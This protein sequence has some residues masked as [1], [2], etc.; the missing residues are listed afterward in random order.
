MHILHLPRL[1]QTMQSGVINH[2]YVTEGSSFEVGDVLYEL[3]TEKMNTDVEAKLPG[4]LA[5][6]VN[7]VGVEI[8]IGATLAVVADPGET[9][10]EDDIADALAGEQAGRPVG[11]GEPRHS[12]TEP[13]GADPSTRAVRGPAGTYDP[14]PV[15]AADP[16]PARVRAMPRARA[17][18]AER[19]L[20]LAAISGTGPG[21]SI[22]VADV[23]N[24]AVPP[25]AAGATEP[26]SIVAVR[27]RR[28]VR[29]IARAM[30]ENVTRS[31]REVPQFVQQTR[32]DA[33]ALQRRR[34]DAA[35]RGAPV[36]LTA[37]LIAAIAHAVKAV[38]EANA[39]FQGEEIVLYSDVNVSV[40]IAT[41][42][43]LI[44]PVLHG[45]QKLDPA[46]VASGVRDLAD[47]AST[48]RLGPGDF[49]SGTIT[50]S[51]LGM[52][53]VETGFPLVTVPQ[54]VIVFAGAVT[55]RP[56][57]SNGQVLV[58]PELGLAIGFDHRV[59]DGATAARFTSALRGAL[60]SD[61]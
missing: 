33:S 18:A 44:V 45:A 54:A 50:V 27:E 38:P 32:A 56:V 17:L 15:A 36:S 20:D 39:S 28:P 24:A 41:D 37:L 35:D 23:E 5:R 31:W 57:V 22:T 58:R 9:L 60:E 47:K 53:G 51:N 25:S 2:W 40:A 6:L 19:G 61:G 12:G 16:A 14:G 26:A 29:G 4:T 46:G 59:L 7:E 49:S 3:E 30:A 55:Q 1:G 48:G 8:P 42:H 13:G 11:A 10:T 34:M 21:G 43:G 52:F